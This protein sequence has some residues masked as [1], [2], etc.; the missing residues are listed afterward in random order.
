MEREQRSWPPPF[1]L[2]QRKSQRALV[3]LAQKRTLARMLRSARSPQ[4][5]AML[6]T[7][8]QPRPVMLVALQSMPRTLAAAK[9]L[10]ARSFA[11]T[12]AQR[13]RAVFSRRCTPWVSLAQAAIWIPLLR[14]VCQLWAAA[15][16]M[17]W[18]PD[19]PRPG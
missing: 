13:G 15:W 2:A 7:L 16:P 8:G 5:A 10:V 3:M 19:L 9:R 4:V 17:Q 18:E 12:V 1:G 6:E 14:R 11:A